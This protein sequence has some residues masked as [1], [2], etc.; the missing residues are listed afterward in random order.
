MI[1]TT[2]YYYAH[3]ILNFK[4]FSFK[5]HEGTRLNIFCEVIKA[6]GKLEVD[7]KTYMTSKNRNELLEL[8]I[9]TSKAF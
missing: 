9:S 4:L 1:S 5:V 3:F 7:E 8:Y 2:Y 6:D